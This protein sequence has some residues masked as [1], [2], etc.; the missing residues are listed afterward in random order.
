VSLHPSLK[1]KFSNDFKKV[2]NS[3]FVVGTALIAH[4]GDNRNGSDITEEAFNN[5]M[6]SLGLIPVVGNWIPEKNNFGGHDITLEWEG[7]NLILKDK[8]IPFG[9]VKENHNA[10]W[11]EIEENG[12]THKYLKADVVLWYGRYTEQIQKVIDDGVN[13]SME[14]NV[15]DY[16][17]KYNSNIQVDKFEYSALCLLGK[18]VDEYGKKGEDNVEPCFPNASIVV[19]KYALSS[20]EFKNK[21]K[22][23]LFAYE[24]TTINN[25]GKEDTIVDENIINNEITNEVSDETIVTTEEYTEQVEENKSVEN[26]E[27]QEEFKEESEEESK[28]LSVEE[29]YE[30]M[31]NEKDILASENDSLKIE[32]Q[33]QKTQIEELES[34]MS[35]LQEYKN[36]TELAKKQAQV[37]DVI[38]EFESVLK[39]VEEFEKIKENAIDYEIDI[40]EEKLS[41]MA[42]KI[43]SKSEKSKK[44]SFSRAVVVPTEDSK[45]DNKYNKYGSAA[46]Y[47]KKTN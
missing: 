29:L 12:E 32:L 5:A 31:S 34:Q 22:Q 10:E 3:E 33:K 36:K 24:Q 25:D 13:Q 27:I 37:D 9:C 7:N 11:V 46:K 4:T 23:F 41:A 1:V 6:P 20:D 40:L 35:E 44:N 8:T 28:E 21:F 47:F 26:N 39:D 17:E 16:S 45:E 15:F 43:K 42:W 30:I 18:E 38:Q 19:D 14:I 2:E